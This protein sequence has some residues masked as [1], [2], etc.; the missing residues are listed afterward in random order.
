MA[1]PLAQRSGRG[2]V[3]WAAL[4]LA[5]GVALRVLLAQHH[6]LEGDSGL[7]LNIS[8]YAVETIIDGTMRLQIDVHPPLHFLLVKAWTAVAGESL[9]SLRLMNILMDVLLGACVAALALRAYNRTA[10]L[11][12]LALWCVAP[13]LIFMTYLV[14]MYTLLALCMAAGALCVQRAAM[15]GRGAHGVLWYGGAGLCAL[16]A[17]YAQVGG[18]IVWGALLCGAVAAVVLEAWRWRAWRTAHSR[19]LMRAVVPFAL[20]LLVYWPFLSALLGQYGQGRTPPTLD[21]AYAN[22][23]SAAFTIVGVA[24]VYA[25]MH[26]TLVVIVLAVIALVWWRWR[27]GTGA[28]VL[29]ALGGAAWCGMVLLAVVADLYRPRYFTSFTPL[30]LALLGGGLAA[31]TSLMIPRALDEAAHVLLTQARHLLAVRWLLR[32]ITMSAVT[33]LL[34][35]GVVRD[36]ARAQYEDFAAAAAFVAQQTRAG[37]VVIVLPDWGMDAFSYHYDGAAPLQKTVPKVADDL[38]FDDLMRGWTDGYQRAWVVLYHPFLTDPAER[39]AAWLE[40]NATIITQVY[41]TN[42]Y[43]YGYDL[44]PIRAALPADARPLDATFDRVIALRGVHL[45]VT[46]GRAQDWRLHPPSAWVHVTL[47]WEVLIDAPAPPF[48]TPQVRLTAPDGAV[49]G[50]N[51]D[52]P[53]ARTLFDRSPPI[54][55]RPRQLWAHAATLNIN[56]NAPAGVYNIEVTVLNGNDAARLPASGADAGASWVIA[57]QYT[58]VPSGP[59]DA[60]LQP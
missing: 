12:A 8:R 9:L 46:A 39:T 30:L 14:R 13:P 25:P 49:Y 40:A 55:W 37:D 32:A 47:Y 57:G 38:P 2:F 42:F 29:L 17:L 59:F 10:A 36:L 20:A 24:L 26:N 51:I 56:P 19:A 21:E 4:L 16:V 22:P 48:V 28:L 60:L 45:P 15:A 5:L 53:V 1:R 31:L 35:V 23:I 11:M 44:Q 54:T 50:D 58:L 43:I 6:G 52:P 27:W 34:G 41:P 3:G 33:V 18:V 7:S